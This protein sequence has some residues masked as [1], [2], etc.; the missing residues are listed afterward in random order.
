MSPFH[1]SAQQ[2]FSTIVSQF[3][4]QLHKTPY[5]AACPR[6]GGAPGLEVRQYPGPGRPW[7]F[8]LCRKCLTARQVYPSDSKFDEI[9]RALIAAGRGGHE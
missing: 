4:M 2:T 7:Y 1:N 8:V 9:M 6:C 3:W 5:T